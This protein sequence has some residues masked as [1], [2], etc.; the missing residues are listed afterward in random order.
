MGGSAWSSDTAVPRIRYL[1]AAAVSQTLKVWLF[2]GIGGSDGS[3][4]L[5]AVDVFSSVDG[6][7]PTGTVS[8]DSGQAATNTFTV[9][10]TANAT[11]T[12]SGVANV[13][14]SSKSTVG[15]NGLLSQGDEQSYVA[16][17]PI[18]W[19]LTN[20]TYGGTPMQGTRWVYVQ[21]EDGAGQ[22]VARPQRLDLRRHDPAHDH[23]RPLGAA[24]AQH[25]ARAP[26]PGR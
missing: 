1:G 20:A 25:R 11:D 6:T 12:G 3:T 24:A 17:T 22:L 14:L 4:P 9:N 26:A 15:S 23:Q 5:K 7:P 19:D 16:D 2:G 18:S 13:L 10:V 8:I 21:W